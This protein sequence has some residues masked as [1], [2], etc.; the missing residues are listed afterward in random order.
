ME[1]ITHVEAVAVQVKNVGGLLRLEQA[2]EARDDDL[3]EVR[4]LHVQGLGD[5]LQNLNR[6]TEPTNQ[7]NQSTVKQTTQR[8]NKPKAFVCC[9]LCF[10]F[11]RVR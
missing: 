8:T 9:V 7:S 6:I 10:V 3:E 4:H 11:P 2:P 5:D 1:G